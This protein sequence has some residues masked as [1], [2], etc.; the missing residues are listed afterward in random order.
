[1][2]SILCQKEKERGMEGR[3]EEVGMD[4]EGRQGEGREQ[5]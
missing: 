3:E 1:M 5:E 2:T 4:G